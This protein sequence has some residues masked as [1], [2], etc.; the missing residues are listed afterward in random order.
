MAIPVNSRVS[1]TAKASSRNGR[2]IW[3]F[4]GLADNENADDKH[5]K[6]KHS[7][8]SKAAAGL[9]IAPLQDISI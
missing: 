2:P 8:E 7:K 9:S 3:T 6:A 5:S 1:S 4:K